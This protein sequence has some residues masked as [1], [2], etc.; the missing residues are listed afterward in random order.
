MAVLVA[1]CAT[2]S[3][4]PEP[5]E[6]PGPPVPAAPQAGHPNIVFVLTDD[7]EP[8]LLRFMPHVQ[9]M[10]AQGADFTNYSVADTLCCPSR[11][12][13]FSGKYPHDTGVFTNTSPD[14]GFDVFHGRG[15][16]QDT[17]AT[18]LQRAGYHTAMMGKYLNGYEP[19]ATQGGP[20]PYVPPGWNQWDVAGS[21]YKEFNYDLNTNG[22]VTHHGNAPQDYLTDVLASKSEAFVRAQ[23]AARQPFLLEVA[24]FAPHGP[25]TPAPRNANDFPGLGAPRDPSFNQPD[26]PTAPAWLRAR[27]PLDPKQITRIDQGY[28][29][30]AQA[31]EAVD[32]LIGRL[33][34]TLAQTGQAA[35]TEIVFSS[36]NGYHMGQHELMPGKQTAFTTDLTVPL[37]VTGPGVVPG[38]R[39]PQ[40]A[41]NVDLAPTFLD[42]AHA[43]PL[44][45]AD[46]HTLTPLLAG[47]SPPD[48]RS[49]ALVEHHGPNTAPGDPDRATG[50]GKAN[51]PSYTGISTGAE[52]YVEYVTGEREYY[53]NRADPY[54]RTNAISTLPPARQAAMHA[55][56]TAFAGCHDGLTCWL[57]ARS[58]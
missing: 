10:A 34:T 35:N 41:Q 42:L 6:L 14:G 36:D 4:P 15:E 53:D 31:V 52:T 8:S 29:E 21:G 43:P 18:T 24:T 32:A 23:A 55:T 49:A 22:Q 12:S 37:V 26:A 9:Q 51:P 13:I 58:P 46:G 2:G 40:L 57:A 7:L 19:T 3:P 27:P 25:Y 1:G 54:Q 17:F 38:R 28:R 11:S 45:H 39:I 56:L 5:P 30:R 16:E 44:A 48:W 50:R 47:Q 33:D 20:G